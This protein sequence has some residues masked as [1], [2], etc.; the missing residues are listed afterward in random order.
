MKITFKKILLFLSLLLGAAFICTSCSIQDDEQYMSSLELESPY[1]DWTFEGFTV[2]KTLNKVSSNANVEPITL[3]LSRIDSKTGKYTG[4]I[5]SN[6]FE[7]EFAIT[8]K[9][10]VISFPKDN[11]FTTTVHET[12]NGQLFFTNLFAVTE[13]RVYP[14]KLHL[15]YSK[16]E[17]M[18]FSRS[19][20]KSR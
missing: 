3:Q 16:D 20:E 11:F 15:Y 19:S 14:D 8:S 13:Y 1:G 17:Y 2:N 6:K 4:I 9:K 5:G 12:T 7:G 18:L 10:R